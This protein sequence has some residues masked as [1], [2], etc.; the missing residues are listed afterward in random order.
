MTDEDFITLKEYFNMRLKYIEEKISERLESQEKAVTVAYAASN[1]RLDGLNEIRQ[2]L[3]DQAKTFI[4][5][6]EFE[7]Y[8]TMI[9]QDLAR[10]S[11]EINSLNLSRAELSGKASQG[12]V[13]LSLII[14]IT[15]LILSIVKMFMN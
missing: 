13:I 9:R 12:Q 3:E 4:T 5:K 8:Q 6:V 15:G 11:T 2:I 14:G 7:T 1:K 10:F